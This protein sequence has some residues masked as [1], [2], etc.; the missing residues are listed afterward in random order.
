MLAEITHNFT[1]RRTETELTF[2]DSLLE[3]AEELRLEASL[4]LAPQS[5]SALGQYF[6]SA[7]VA[8]LMAQMV[9]PRPDERIRLLDAGAGT[10]I[11]TAAF[12]AAACR[13]RQKPHEVSVKAF[14]I[15]ANLLPYLERTFSACRNLCRKFEIK[16][17]FEIEN[18]NFIFESA[19][20]LSASLFSHNR[21]SF[22]LILLNPPYGKINTSSDVS[23]A[24]RAVGIE[25]PNL[26]AAFLA[27]S[28]EL[29]DEGGQMVAITPRS[30]C[31]GTY[32]RRFRRFFLER[33]AFRRSHVFDSRLAAFKDDDVLQE[34]VIFQAI[35]SD[36]K[37][38]KIIVSTSETPDEA[39]AFVFRE[40]EASE[41]I[42]TE[43]KELFIHLTTDESNN[44]K[45]SRIKRFQT[46]LAGL[47]LSVSTGR[48]VDFRVKDF[49]R[50]ELNG[51]NTAPLIYPHHLKNGFVRY[52]NPHPKK[53]EAI[54]V[55]DK[56][57]NLF[58]ETGIYVLVKRFSAKEERRR[59]T[60]AIFEPGCVK[61]E[62]IGFENHLNYFHA[63]GRGIETNLARGLALYLNSSLVD[64][65]FRQFNGHTQVNA[66]DLRYLKYP[67]L[68][69]LE[70]LGK[71]IRDSFP[72]QDEIDSL[73]DRFL[74][75]D[76]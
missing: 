35:K 21:Q 16:F 71:E 12:V 22:D 47:G 70:N 24:L 17:S 52:P 60:A 28:A 15:D 27:L 25:T 75:A 64:T 45:A 49:L 10:G 6:T 54:V 9:E 5:R 3:Q 57:E 7:A 26:Y 30:F 39:A 63:N 31:N 55:A 62:K 51:E 46:E 76:E 56:T 68:G 29:L 11:L 13:W 40:I 66:G 73:I 1:N 23:R 42:H 53:C 34:N 14:E 8:R 4:K 38:G 61:R 19:S 65:Y 37:T 43:D 44:K 41:L 58:V 32:F 69:E 20:Q 18:K 36:D 72:D 2:P 48:V 74:F 67:T 33:M 50:R 59:I